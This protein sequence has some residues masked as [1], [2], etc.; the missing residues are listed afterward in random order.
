MVSVRWCL[1][2]KNGFELVEP[3]KNMSDSYLKMAEESLKAIRNNAESKIWTASTAYYTLYYSLYAVMMRVGVKCEVHQC[4]IEF[5]KKFLDGFYSKED[6]KLIESAFESRKDLQYYPN[7]LID[8]SKLDFVKAGAID[9][10]VKTKDILVK[11]S[12]SRVK[13]VRNKFSEFVK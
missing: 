1:K 2:I 11:I 6:V 4:S 13:E 3:N 9:F 10:F 8:Q 7:R 12:D 5:M